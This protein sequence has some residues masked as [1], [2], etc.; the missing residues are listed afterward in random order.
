MPFTDLCLKQA[1]GTAL[2]V[3]KPYLGEG[4]TGVTLLAGERDARTP[5]EKGQ[6]L[7]CE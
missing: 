1:P 6:R 3:L 2:C 5:S 7:G 4:P